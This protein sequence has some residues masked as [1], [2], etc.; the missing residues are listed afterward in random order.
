MER[1]KRSAIIYKKTS[2]LISICLEE[3]LPKTDLPSFAFG[4]SIA[5]RKAYGA[6]LDKFASE[7]PNLVGGSADLEPSNYTGNF[8]ET[9][10]D[11]SKL[12]Q[13]G[14]IIPFGA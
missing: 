2:S 6:T 1:S 4:E 8:A 13:A 11:F 7:L 12:D 5:T 3:K 14:R 10:K 9:Y